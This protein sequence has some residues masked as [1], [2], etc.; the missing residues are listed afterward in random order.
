M[1]KRLELYR[2]E[3][4]GNIV[5]IMHEGIGELVCCGKPMNL[6]IPHAKS[7][8]KQEKHVPVIEEN[9]VKIGTIPHPMVEEH[10]I[11]FIQAINMNKNE[12]KT[13]FLSPSDAPEMEIEQNK[14]QKA[15]EYCNIHGLWA[16]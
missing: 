4:C 8:E 10:Y 7:E 3:V 1:T 9:K 14:Y 13:K 16:N 6:L 5:Q 15:C 2:C 12:I 11:E